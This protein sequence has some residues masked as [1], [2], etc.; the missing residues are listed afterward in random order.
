MGA[1]RRELG[2]AQEKERMRSV[3]VAHDAAGASLRHALRCGRVR[4][5][6]ESPVGPHAHAPQIR[7]RKGRCRHRPTCNSPGNCRQKPPRIPVLSTL[8]RAVEQKFDDA[9]VAQ[10]SIKDMIYSCPKDWKTSYIQKYTAKRGSPL[11]EKT[12]ASFSRQILEGMM[13]LERKGWPYQVVST[14]NVLLSRN[15]SQCHLCDVE[16]AILGITP[17]FAHLVGRAASVSSPT[18]PLLPLSECTRA[19]ARRLR[20]G[21]NSVWTHRVR[22]RIIIFRA[23]VPAQWSSGFCI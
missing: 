11:P 12:V 22:N 8:L 19:G 16:S 20:R 6:V 14:G 1:A 7:P 10:G 17:R 9:C 4:H 5:L 3:S 18:P 15:Q 2:A 13:F 21:D 23:F